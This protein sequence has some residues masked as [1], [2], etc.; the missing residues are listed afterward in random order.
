MAEE[1]C[2]GD[3]VTYP[4]SAVLN[5]EHWHLSSYIHSISV[6]EEVKQEGSESGSGQGSGQAPAP[7]PD[8][9]RLQQQLERDLLA[10][11]ADLPTVCDWGCNTTPVRHR[12]IM[13]GHLV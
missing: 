9:T 6:R 2:L 5:T 8:P 1:D 7:P 10:N 12:I 4:P 11:L 13:A 3:I